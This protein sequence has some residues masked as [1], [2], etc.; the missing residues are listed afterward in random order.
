[1]DLKQQPPNR[2]HL[3]VAAFNPNPRWPGGYFEV[4]EEMGVPEK[5]HGFYAQWVREL[6]NDFP[7]FMVASLKSWL[8]KPL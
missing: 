8:R 5:Q 2:A 4:L 6:F 3:P 1:M 7:G